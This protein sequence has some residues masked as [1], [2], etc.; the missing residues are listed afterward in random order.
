VHLAAAHLLSPCQALQIVGWLHALLLEED[1]EHLHTSV[2]SY[3]EYALLLLKNVH[4]SNAYVYESRID[5]LLKKLFKKYS[6]T[7]VLTRSLSELLREVWGDLKLKYNAHAE[8]VG[9]EEGGDRREE[10]RLGRE[11]AHVDA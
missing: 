9:N 1:H 3:M 5:K 8:M 2:T 10:R 7:A 6:S 11:S 4:L